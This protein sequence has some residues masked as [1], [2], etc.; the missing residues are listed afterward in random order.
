MGQNFFASIWAKIVTPTLLPCYICGTSPGGHPTRVRMLFETMAG[1]DPWTCCPSM[2]VVSWA[3]KCVN[4]VHVACHLG[5][6]PN[7]WR[8]FFRHL[9]STCRLQFQL[10]VVA[11]NQ[12][13]LGAFLNQQCRVFPRAAESGL[14]ALL[15]TRFKTPFPQRPPIV[16][17]CVRPRPPKSPLPWPLSRPGVCTNFF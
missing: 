11:I 17:P 3:E 12:G 9:K 14:N 2:A 6:G 8:G 13:V 16:R 10:W 15:T 5:T 4:S 7:L 1:G